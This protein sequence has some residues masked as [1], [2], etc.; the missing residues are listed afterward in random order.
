MI[1]GE[2]RRLIARL[3]YADGRVRSIDLGDD[4]WPRALNVGRSFF[5]ATDDYYNCERIYREVL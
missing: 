5:R 2:L 3:M 4:E 1:Q